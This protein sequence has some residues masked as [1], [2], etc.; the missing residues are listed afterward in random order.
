[1]NKQRDRAMRLLRK[2]LYRHYRRVSVTKAKRELCG[3]EIGSGST[4]VVY[5]CKVNKDYVVKIAFDGPDANILEHAV[6]DYIFACPSI[7]KWFAE[8]VFLS[9][10]GMVLV[11]K[12]VSFPEN[13]EYPKQI[14]WYFTDIKKNNFGFI[15]GRLVCVDYSNAFGRLTQYMSNKKMRRA[16][17][18]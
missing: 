6:W 5:E 4:R 13:A 14:P 12:K 3:K 8:C 17:W 18:K 9:Q 7:A 2:I 1:M 11:Q 16:V 15:D 10:N